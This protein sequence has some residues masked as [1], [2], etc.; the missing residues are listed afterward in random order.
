VPIPTDPKVKLDAI[1][2]R[3][4]AALRFSGYTSPKR[5]KEFE[6]KLMNKLNT[7]GIRVIGPSF[8]MRYNSPFAVGFMRRNEV[9][10]EIALD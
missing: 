5:V 4:V 1:P 6:Q 10:V 3:T 2:E 9:A 7:N 8:L